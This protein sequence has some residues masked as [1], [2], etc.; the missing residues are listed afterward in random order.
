M[1][2]M[3]SQHENWAIQIMNIL[4]S[5]RETMSRG[6]SFARAFSTQARGGQKTA[7]RKRFQQQAQKRKLGKKKKE[8]K[9]NVKVR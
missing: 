8:T 4:T 6:Q 5:K 7:P 2:C 3:S 1:P 9:I